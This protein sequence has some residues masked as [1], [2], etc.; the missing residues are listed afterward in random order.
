MSSL[1]MNRKILVPMVKALYRFY[2]LTSMKKNC[3]LMT[4]NPPGLCASTP[5]LVGFCFMERKCS[6]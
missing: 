4:A 1:V 2:S 5:K 6:I 3:I